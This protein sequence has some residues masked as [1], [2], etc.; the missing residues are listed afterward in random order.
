M[1]QMSAVSL[2]WSQA[3][4][5]CKSIQK[6]TEVNYHTLHFTNVQVK[7]K[8][9]VKC[10]A[11]L[12]ISHHLTELSRNTLSYSALELNVFAKLAFL[13]NGLKYHNYYKIKKKT[14]FLLIN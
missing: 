13:S 8:V 5:K 14:F 1:F 2:C 9:K 12:Y 10:S 11:V 6:W 3:V 7:V 4:Q